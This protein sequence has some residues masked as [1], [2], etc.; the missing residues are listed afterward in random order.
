MTMQN[1]KPETFAPRLSGVQLD[2][3]DPMIM[4]G[5]QTKLMS[6]EIATSESLGRIS[7]R[8]RTYPMIIH[9]KKNSI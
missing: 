3:N 7:L 5:M 1:N 6:L 2:R 4:A 9:R 8:F